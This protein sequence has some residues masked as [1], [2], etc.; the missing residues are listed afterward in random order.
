M[1]RINQ[2][3]CV[4]IYYMQG[5][6]IQVHNGRL[7]A[8]RY[9]QTWLPYVDTAFGRSPDQVLFAHWNINTTT[10]IPFHE[11]RLLDRIVEVRLTPDLPSN[12]P[13]YCGNFRGPGAPGEIR[14]GTC[15][16]VWFRDDNGALDV[17]NGRYLFYRDANGRHHCV[18]LEGATPHEIFYYHWI[19][20]RNAAGQITGLVP[21]IKSRTRV[22]GVFR[23]T[24]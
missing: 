1:P 21:E 16:G 2:G 14:P 8:A 15:V 6:T 20:E 12:N 5:N 7:I 3:S 17:K 11:R 4:G 18:L 9:G 24:L 19:V 22:H 13:F 10:G 23:N